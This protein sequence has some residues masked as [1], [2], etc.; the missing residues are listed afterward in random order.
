MSTSAKAKRLSE[1]E[2]HLTPKEWA[3]RLTEEMR[4]HPRQEDFW[5]AL[6]KGT[7]RDSPVVKPF[8][9]LAEQAE[10]R[11]PG[12]NPANIRLQD[13]LNRNL[14]MEF[15]ALRGLVWNV[16]DTI[17]DKAELL[18]LKVALKLSR[19][20]SII[21]LDAFARSCSKAARG[22]ERQKTADTDE[23]ERQAV[24]RNLD[25]SMH[26]NFGQWPSDSL[27]RGHARRLH[28]PPLIEDW[29]NES[30]MLVM[31]VF[32]HRAALQAVQE[33]YFDGHPILFRDVEASLEETIATVEKT[34]AAFNEYLETRADLL[35]T[36][37]D[38]EKRND[39]LPSATPHE[40]GSCL[41][42]C[43]EAIQ[44]RAKDYIAVFMAALWVKRAQ[45]KAVADIL[46]ETQ[47]HEAYIWEAFRERFG[48]KA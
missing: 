23:E 31:D 6:A 32:A 27:P 37:R 48:V 10:D 18:R 29:V 43:V 40:R 30:T 22:I 33:K 35:K 3:I 44:N 9:K 34:A 13:Q 26:M 7:Y 36:Q 8:F 19:L 45:E 46:K 24:L 20:H 12:N 25:T 41:T 39:Q 14:R 38:Q 15:A 1:A 2:I 5:K 16:N 17:N 21:L 11:H 42:I 28:T 47:E 4:E